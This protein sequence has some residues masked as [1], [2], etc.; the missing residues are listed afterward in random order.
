MPSDDPL[1]ETLLVLARPLIGIG[2]RSVQVAG[3][4]VTIP[5]YRVLV[6]LDDNGPL[7]I[8]AIALEL[9]VNPSNATRVCDRLERLGLL[10]R[11]SAAHDR[12]SVLVEVTDGGREVVAAVTAYRRQELT[13][14][15]S[16]VDAS[17]ST[18]LVRAL[19]EVATAARAVE[20]S[21]LSGGA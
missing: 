8:G 12:R 14:V 1:V 6:L 17:R 3:G 16:R 11:S 20:A 21:D 7:P 5:Q 4:G 13:R 2:V 10:T 19:D 18:A 15:V 9:G